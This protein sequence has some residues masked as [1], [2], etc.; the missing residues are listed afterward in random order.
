VKLLNRNIAHVT[1]RPRDV[2]NAHGNVKQRCWF[3]TKL[4]P[5]ST[6]SCNGKCN[7]IIFKCW[8]FVMSVKTAHYSL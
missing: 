3:Y 1:R 5:R 6:L 4:R 8:P 7:A 2:I